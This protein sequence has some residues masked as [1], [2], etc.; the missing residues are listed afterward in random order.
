MTCL[1]CPEC[2]KQTQQIC[3]ECG[4]KTIEQ[5]HEECMRIESSQRLNGMKMDIITYKQSDHKKVIGFNSV[6]KTHSFRDLLLIFIIVGFFIL[7]F[8]TADYLNLLQSQSDNEKIQSDATKESSTYL[9][10]P[11]HAFYENCLG[12]GN[13][14]SITV[15]CP[16][17]KGYVYKIT[18]FTPPALAAK[19]SSDV[20]SI[21]T[22]SLGES[23]DGFVILKYQKESYTTDFFT[24]YSKT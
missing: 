19:F 17:G 8:A 7:G 2:R 21:R 4:S 6:E 22:I 11:L 10:N 1:S 5:Y 15:T 16:D 9:N 20:F 14:Q 24:K 18:L 12:H 23:L 3:R 13:E